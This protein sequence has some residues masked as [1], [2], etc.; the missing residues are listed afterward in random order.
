MKLSLVV[1]ILALAGLGAISPART[2]AQANRPAQTFDTS[3]GPVKVTPLYHATML[4]EAGGKNIYVDP[5][6][7]ANFTGFPKADLILITDIHGDHM[8]PDSIAGITNSTTKIFAPPAVV[9]TVSTAGPISNG[10]SKSWNGWTIEAIPMY[11]LKRGPSPGQLYHDKG[12]GN[13][14]VLTYGGKRFYISGDTEGIPEMRALKNIDV[15]FVCMNLPYTM[16][17]EEAADAVKVFHPK[18][19]I[20]YHFHGSDL[21]VFEKA[22]KGSGIE[23]RVLDWYPSA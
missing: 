9:K 7:P 12:R 6:K 18:I 19:V 1:P 22:L 20:P 10:E 14:Y 21:A 23:V 16:P 5:A 11:N 13:G 2:Q 17:P 4:I 8:D 15:A 3:A